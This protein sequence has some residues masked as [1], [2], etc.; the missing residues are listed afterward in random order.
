MPTEPIDPSEAKC[1]VKRLQ[2]ARNFAV[3]F[4]NP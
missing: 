2:Q 4:T 1:K 3:P